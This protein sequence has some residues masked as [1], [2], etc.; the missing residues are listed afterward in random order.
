MARQI[1]EAGQRVVTFIIY[2]ND[3]Y[4]G[5]E[6]HFPRLGLSHRGRAGDALYFANTGP[7]GAPDPRTLHA[8]LP[9]TAG[10]KWL[11]SQWIRNRSRS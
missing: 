10:E 3:D 11:F 2:L 9:P 1:A 8:G 5:G 7:D 4:Q 6:T